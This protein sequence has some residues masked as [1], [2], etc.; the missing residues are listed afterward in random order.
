MDDD[1][2]TDQ[3]ATHQCSPPQPVSADVLDGLGVLS[4]SGITGDEDPLLAKIRADR[5]YSY[6]DVVH[7]CPE[8]LPEYETKIRNFYREHIHYDEE[9]RY[10]M[11]GSGY[12]DVRDIDDRWIRINL[13]AG[14]MIILPEGIY[15][16]FTCDATNYAKAMRLF[17]GE[18]I[19]TPY[20]RDEIDEM[21]N[22]SRVRYVEAFLANNKRRRL[23][24]VEMSG[25]VGL[26]ANVYFDGK[27]VS[28]TVTLPSGEKKSVGVIM[29]SATPLRFDISSPEIMEITDGAVAVSISGAPE[30]TLTAGA[31]WKVGA[32]E[33]FTV[34]SEAPVHYIC[35]FG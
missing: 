1:I 23:S 8:K 4:W 11:E 30:Q 15:H 10:I 27:V 28:H 9:I 7:V 22:A 26:K 16:R 18:P 2:T 34:K 20:N 12:F 33:Y 25:S 29:P 3:R 5:G 14:D 17:V 19:W 6:T 35:H 31:T 13:Q 21:K 24:K 32:G